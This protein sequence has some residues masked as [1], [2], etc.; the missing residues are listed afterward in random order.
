MTEPSANPKEKEF[1]AKDLELQHALLD[2]RM[3]TA[4][5]I[6]MPPGGGGTPHGGT[7]FL[8]QGAA[9]ILRESLPL[10]WVLPG[11]S[12]RSRFSP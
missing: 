2:L 6:A 7:A 5:K 4:G 9:E 10:S 8:G 3:L 12:S 1:E 11:A